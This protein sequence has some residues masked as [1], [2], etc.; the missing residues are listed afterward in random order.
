MS[1]TV[2]YILIVVV[3]AVVAGGAYQYFRTEQPLPQ[4]PIASEPPA[5]SPPAVAAPKPD[6]GNFQ[7]RFQPSMPASNGASK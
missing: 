5:A 3:A 2:V 6:H 1:K 7:K 4:Q